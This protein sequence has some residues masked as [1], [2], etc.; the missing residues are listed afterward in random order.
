M[1]D[2]MLPDPSPAIARVAGASAAQRKAHRHFLDGRVHAASGQ[3][4]GAA[5]AYAQAASLL[6]DSA[7]ALAAAHAAIKAG[8]PRDAIER[9][10]RLRAAQPTLTLA[11]TMESL[12]WS[13]LC[14]DDEA[15]AVLQALPAEAVRDHSYHSQLAVGLQKLQ[16]HDA[17]VPAFL[18][19]LALKL[20]DAMSHFRLGMSFKDMGL[21]AEAAECVRTALAL[22]LGSSELAARA[23]M[24]FLEREACRWSEAET[25][26]A[27]LRL[28]VQRAPDDAPLETGAFVHAVLV[29]DA[30]EQRKV[31]TLYAR[32][33]ESSVVPLPRRKAK[34]HDGRLR[35]G[36]LSADFHQ[37]ATSQ[38]A[39]Q[40]FE[41]HDRGRFEV[42]LFSA[43]QDD[44]TP[45]RRRMQAATEHFVELR[46]LAPAQMA[47]AI[48]ERGIDILVDAKGATAGSVM[49]VMAYRPAPV[50]VNW[51]GF[52]GTSG[53][54]YIDY[55]IG[56]PVVTPLAHAA[57]FSEC[58]AQ[59][60][61]CYQPNDSRR[62]LPQ[63]QPRA[64]WGLPD[65]VPVLCGFHQAYKISR[66][67]FATWCHL[68]H[69]LPRAVLWLL[70]WNANVEAALTQAAVAEGIDASRLV[71][72]PLL[73]ADRHLSRP[74]AADV[75]LDTWPCNGHTTIS[76][77][78][79]VGVPPVT[80]IGETFAQRVAASLLHASDLGELVC[81]DAAGYEQAVQTLVAQP[82]RSAALRQRLIAQ[83][84]QPLFDGTSFARDIE[85]L[86]ERMWQRATAGLPPEHLAAV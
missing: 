24:V 41:A 45:L 11:Y 61:L 14:R 57:H 20:D 65:G 3:W 35:V 9:L 1:T 13:E 60:P 56:D 40:M 10:R 2:L 37:H 42:T 28:A 71:F 32:H 50:Q 76:E 79:W 6:H 63:P 73:P 69:A 38:L 49:K 34:T 80:V 66:E 54:R 75:F 48:R 22:G 29:N 31:A 83:R 52:P 86:F 12:A 53:A 33:L 5:R 82:Q 43:G 21:K 30:L 44:G 23:L 18:A 68:L 19:A 8:Q 16:R 77:A 74:G 85:A 70:R 46:G 36:Y 17:A 64:A 72:A 27:A 15:V 55:L 4:P 78:L 7:Y 58:I 25:E 26:V 62:A 81:T 84:T 47:A 39:V 67:V 51:L 59:M